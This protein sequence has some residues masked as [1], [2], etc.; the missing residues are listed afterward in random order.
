MR[1]QLLREYAVQ[2]KWFNHWIQPR[3]R[4]EQAD[5]IHAA[6]VAGA[7]L[8][9][10]VLAAL[11]PNPHSV[12]ML[13]TVLAV[14]GSLQYTGSIVEKVQQR[15]LGTLIGGLGG[16]LAVLIAHSVSPWGAA[17]LELVIAVTAAYLS[18]GRL[19]YAALVCGITM[20]MVANSGDMQVAFWRVLNVFLGGLSALAFAYLIPSRASEHWFYLLGGN[21][22]DQLRLYQ[23]VMC[24]Q[25][26]D[27]ELQQAVMQRG[28]RL[29]A[30]AAPAGH[31]SHLVS[32]RFETVLH[33]QRSILA[34]LEVMAEDSSEHRATGEI[35][36]QIQALFQKSLARFGL[37]ALVARPA[38]LSASLWPGH[39]LEPRILQQLELLDAELQ[40]LLPSLLDL[41]P[42]CD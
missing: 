17:L 33:L 14:M 1:Y 40:T 9:C 23:G 32:R 25:G 21:L 24:G 37:D 31:E 27:L 15:A 20:V 8:V 26:L 3:F 10:L 5:R 11:W 35:A 6:R 30:L 42:A 28:L 38:S 2:N 19:G 39:W 12:W 41:V 7:F 4:Y 18:I 29:Q 34:L 13:I 16:V 22:R 36:P